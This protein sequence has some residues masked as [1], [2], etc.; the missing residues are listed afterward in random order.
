MDSRLL[1]CGFGGAFVGGSAARV[2]VSRTDAR[3]S[4]SALTDTM[5]RCMMEPLAKG[6]GIE[7]DASR[8][9]SPRARRPCVQSNCLRY[10]FILRCRLTLVRRLDGRLVLLGFVGCG[11]LGLGQRRR[12]RHRLD[13]AGETT[14]RAKLIEATAAETGDTADTTES[15]DPTSAN[16]GTRRRRHAEAAVA[17]RPNSPDASRSNSRTRFPQL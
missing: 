2:Q 8:R 7:A 5:T 13:H 10:D 6:F 9:L 15:A 4:A 17:I 3:S 16:A 14:G 12:Q 11:L 1:T